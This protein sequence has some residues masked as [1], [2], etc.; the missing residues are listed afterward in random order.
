M[1][2]LEALNVEKRYGP[3]LLFELETFRMYSGDRIGLVGANGA[4][5]TTLLSIL[6]GQLVPD[7]GTV[8]C[9]GVC[10]FLEQLTVD[11]REGP[12][13]SKRQAGTFRTGREF[14]SHLSGGEKTRFRLA[15]ILAEEPDILLADEPTAHLDLQGIEFLEDKLSRFSGA[16]LVVSHDR[17]FLDS[18][19]EK[20]LEIEAGSF[21]LYEGGYSKYRQQKEA[22]TRREK[23]EY[24]QFLKE[25]RRLEAAVR[26]TRENSHKMRGTPKRMGNSEARLHKRAAG[27][28]KAKLS[29]QARGLESRLAHLESKDKP[30]DSEEL[31]LQWQN[32][33]R[34]HSSVLIRAADLSKS[35]GEGQ[36]FSG[37]SFQVFEGDKVALMGS[38]GTGKTT[39]LKMV[40][41]RESTLHI[42]ASLSIG[43]FSQELD[44][45]DDSLSLL[46]NA[47][48]DSGH[49]E[50]LIRSVL[51]RLGFRREAVFQQVAM[52]SGGER[53]KLCLAKLLL[54]PNNLLL[55]DEPSNFLDL[56]TQEALE[57]LLLDYPGTILFATHDR[58]L[59][60]EVAQ[61]LVILE[62]SRSRFF[63]GSMAELHEKRMH[64]DG[65]VHAERMVVENRLAEITGRLSMPGAGD[66]VEA[67]DKEFKVLVARRRE[68]ESKG[69]R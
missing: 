41:R 40:L 67:L 23:A 1:L 21:F 5:K 14:E 69:R 2:L 59:I 13:L 12:A 8:H 29:R 33:H 7:A 58:R 60:R 39:L 6:A 20:I 18:V 26:E 45:L 49:P 22:K 66:D 47:S 68:L 11:G 19:C 62:G 25:K 63:Q 16:L 36:L 35:F 43:Y 9:F 24:E 3:R 56:E 46:C 17:E 53:V 30:Y 27:T 4:G 44:I 10:S 54:Q 64:R 37:L 42:P 28:K 50:S 51:G 34:P 52:L 15:E 65:D 38:N 55:L 32:V 57:K 48:K 61:K 31:R